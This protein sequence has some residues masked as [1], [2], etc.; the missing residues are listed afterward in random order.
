M[1]P[2]EPVPGD[3][4]QIKTFKQFYQEDYFSFS[5]QGASVDAQLAENGLDQISVVPNPYVTAASWERRNLN[6]TGRGERKISFINL[7][8]ECTIRI[9]TVAGD[10]VKTL[11]KDYSPTD[12]SLTWNLVSEDGMDVASGLYIYHV[13]TPDIG[14]YINKF[15]LIK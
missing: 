1:Q 3:V 15:A 8:A 14:D 5:T 13:E 11:Y 9:Y 6:Q 4:F 12:G 7:P 10:L 2:K